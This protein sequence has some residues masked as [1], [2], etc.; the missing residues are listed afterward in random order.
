M[1]TQKELEEENMLLRAAVQ[2]IFWMARRYAHG[3]HTYA[4]GMV[5]EA[6][7]LAKELGIAIQHD[8]VIKPPTKNVVLGFRSDWLDDCND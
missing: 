4:P 2:N 7:Q 8:D 1:K 3:R 5:R 6:Y